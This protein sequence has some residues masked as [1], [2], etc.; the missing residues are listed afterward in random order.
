MISSLPVTYIFIT[1]ARA[2]TVDLKIVNI[3]FLAAVFSYHFVN[4]AD[5]TCKK[6]KLVEE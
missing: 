2:R 3:N 5:K 4:Q 6:T 1:Q